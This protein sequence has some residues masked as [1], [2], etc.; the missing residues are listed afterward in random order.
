MV[1]SVPAGLSGKAVLTSPSA[2]SARALSASPKP[3]APREVRG[4]FRT[5]ATSAP[6]LFVGEHLPH[7]ADV[8]VHGALLHKDVIPP[9]FVEKL[10][11]AVDPIRVSHEEMQQPKL[12]SLEIDFL[13]VTGNTM[14]GRIQP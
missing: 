9:D 3:K 7:S 4:E 12:G 6:G 13:T 10:G 11:A 8:N 2:W 14:R 1:S 5:I